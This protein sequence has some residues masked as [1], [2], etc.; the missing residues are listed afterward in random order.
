MLPAFEQGLE[1][2]AFVHLGIAHECDHPPLG[3]ILCP[4]PGLHIVLHEGGEQSLGDAEA[5]GA[6][7]EIHVVGILGARGVALRALVAAEGLQLLARLVAQQILDRVIGGAGMGL[8]RHAILR[9]QHCQI[10][11]GEDGGE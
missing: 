3:P 5:D 9:A 8:H 2:V 7:R 10:E 11:G 1:D 4:S 6:G